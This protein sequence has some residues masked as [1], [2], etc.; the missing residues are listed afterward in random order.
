MFIHSNQWLRPLTAI[1]FD[2]Q[3]MDFNIENNLFLL[4]MFAS[5][6]FVQIE[7]NKSMSYFD[8]IY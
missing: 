4:K 2:P 8:L 3:L 6:R 5:K 1:L 7:R